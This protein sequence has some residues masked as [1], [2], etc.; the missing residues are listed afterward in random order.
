ME[1]IG[2]WIILAL[3]A[4]VAIYFY[5]KSNKDDAAA[6]VVTEQPPK[7]TTPAPL[8]VTPMAGIWQGR[9]DPP[10]QAE[11]IA[12]RD[13]WLA[14]GGELGG[15]VD[16]GIYLDGAFGFETDANGNITKGEFIL[17][18]TQCPTSG[19]VASWCGIP[20]G[21]FLVSKDGRNISGR[22]QEGGAL[23]FKYGN[24]VGIFTAGGKL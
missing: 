14:M 16:G 2:Q 9:V 20:G 1:N 21:E 8:P 6:G 24:I 23:S 7:P 13:K 12:A 10:S 15:G 17:H 19:N 4:A 3:A 11:R 22:V 18:G 5:R